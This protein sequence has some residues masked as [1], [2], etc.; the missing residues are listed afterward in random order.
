MGVL[1]DSSYFDVNVTQ[2]ALIVINKGSFQ[3]VLLIFIWQFDTFV[4]N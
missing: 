4:S 3:A 2:W 1:S